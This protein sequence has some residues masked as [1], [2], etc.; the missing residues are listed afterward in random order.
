MLVGIH[1][2]EKFNVLF[3]IYLLGEVEGAVLVP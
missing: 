1:D 2:N 3:I